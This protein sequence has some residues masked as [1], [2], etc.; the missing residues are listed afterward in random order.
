MQ[1]NV[2][3]ERRDYRTLPRSPVADRHDPVF[4]NPRLQPF[5]DQ[6]DHARVV[7][8]VLQETDQ[9]FLADRIEEAPDIRIENVVHLLARDPDDECVQ[10]I[11]LAA[12]WSEPVREPEKV[13]LVDRVEHRERRPLDNLVF[14]GGDRERALPAIGLRYVPTP[15]RQCPVRSSVDP[16][17]QIGEV[18]LEICLVV[19]PGQPINTR[20]RVAL[21]REEG[22]PEQAGTDVVEERGEPFLLPL[23]CDF[24]YAV[25]RKCHAFPVL[26]PARAL[27]VRIPLGLRPSLHRLRRR[28]PGVVRRLHCYYGGG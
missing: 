22:H 6:T 11:V 28:S 25:Q 10:R 3:Q 20:C 21:E 13:L 16:F 17:M 4:E 19:P 23:P 2:G 18:A 9:P 24:S 5:L 14:D 8:P 1:V 7:D 26:R 27:L 12:L 15:G